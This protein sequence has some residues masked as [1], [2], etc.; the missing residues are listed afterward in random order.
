MRSNSSIRW[1]KPHFLRKEPDYPDYPYKLV[2]ER[3]GGGG[4]GD[5]HH[6]PRPL[7]GLHPISR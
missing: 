7:S 5:L 4:R 6:R 2:E 1:L 3:Y